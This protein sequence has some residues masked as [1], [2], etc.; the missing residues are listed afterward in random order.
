MPSLKNAIRQSD[1]DPYEGFHQDIEFINNMNSIT[2]RKNVNSN[3]TFKV[4]KTWCL[5]MLF[6]YLFETVNN[7]IWAQPKHIGPRN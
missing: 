1:F 7:T 3:Y 2:V 6:I 5:S 4:K